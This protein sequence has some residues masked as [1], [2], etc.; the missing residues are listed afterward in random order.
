[1]TA[2]TAIPASVSSLAHTTAGDVS[3]LTSCLSGST[4]L[5][6]LC[7][8]EQAAMRVL[9]NARAIRSA[10][11]SLKKEARVNEGRGREVMV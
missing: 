3:R 2:R 1:M 4:T 7:H 10:I 11:R 8:A 6:A 9:D 5:A